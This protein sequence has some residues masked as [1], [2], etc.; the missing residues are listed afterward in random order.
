MI[1]GAQPGKRGQAKL[2]SIHEHPAIPEGQNA[3]NPSGIASD[4]GQ[5]ARLWC[6]EIQNLL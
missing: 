4:P 1:L 3:K 2:K 5:Q 6:K